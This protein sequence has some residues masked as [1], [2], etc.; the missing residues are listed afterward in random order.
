MHK[1]IAVQREQD[2]DEPELP[3][4]SPN[5]YE[6]TQ[7]TI[8]SEE[9]PDPRGGMAPI[10]EKSDQKVGTE[11]KVV[12]P[13]RSKRVGAAENNSDLSNLLKFD[14]KP[15]TRPKQV[16]GEQQMLAP[17]PYVQVYQF[18]QMLQTESSVNPVLSNFSTLQNE[19]EHSY[20]SFFQKPG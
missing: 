15:K 11:G 12:K 17:Q 10:I 8:N 18:D 19:T 6:K 5:R 14:S 7:T 16:G 3:H 13:K 9:S 1:S 2:G 20:H 4:E